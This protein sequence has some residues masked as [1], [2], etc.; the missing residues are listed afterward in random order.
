[1][2]DFL[3]EL[4]EYL[5]GESVG[6]TT[7]I[8]VGTLPSDVDDCIALYQ[9]P[10]TNIGVSRDVKDL[11]FPRIQAMVR[12]KEYANAESDLRAVRNALHGQI[13]LALTSWKVLRLHAESEGGFLGKDENGR[14]EFSINFNS[15]IIATS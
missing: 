12:N 7:P 9:L 4:S 15:E 2:S 1:M 13:N 14:T 11:C 10:G 3:D 6:I 8:Y 5:E